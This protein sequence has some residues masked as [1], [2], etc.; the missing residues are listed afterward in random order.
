MLV[1]SLTEGILVFVLVAVREGDGTHYVCSIRLRWNVEITNDGI[2]H[3]LVC[4][5]FGFHNP[6]FPVGL[7]DASVLERVRTDFFCLHPPK[8]KLREWPLD[9]QA[10][11]A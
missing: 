5:S 10:W 3:R 1:P 9:I 7:G 8:N 6:D 2:L 4:G 11:H